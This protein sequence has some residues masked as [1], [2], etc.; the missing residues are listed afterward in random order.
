MTIG[1]FDHLE[2]KEKKALLEKCC[3]SSA[4]V[5]KMISIFPIQNLVDLLEYGEE[6]W[7]E[8]NPADWL[9]AFQSHIPIGDIKSLREKSDPITEWAADEQ[10][11]IMNASPDILGELEKANELYEETFGYTFIIYATGKT[12]EEMLEILN[13]RLLNDPEEELKT[14]GAEQNKITQSRLQKI[15]N[16]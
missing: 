2:I 16:E 4:W 13:Q 14:A 6:E 12:A 7:Y 9:E 1:E 5:K 11:G 10:A 8:C 15:F 3:G